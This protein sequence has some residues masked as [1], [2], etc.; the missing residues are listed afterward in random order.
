MLFNNCEKKKWALIGISVGITALLS[1]YLIVIKDIQSPDAYL[2]G[3]VQYN[4]GDWASACGRWFL[5]YLEK[6]TFNLVMPLFVVIMYAACIV[7]SVSL[8]LRL[9]HIEE[10][11]YIVGISIVMTASPAIIEQL[12][13]TFTALA[14]A[15]SLLLSVGYLFLVSSSRKLYHSF[16]GSICLCLALGLYQSYIGV[17]VGLAAMLLAFEVY[18]DGI[19]RMFWKRVL[20]YI[21]TGG[22]GVLLYFICMKIDSLLHP[23]LMSERVQNISLQSMISDFPERFLYTYQ[24]FF[25]YFADWRMKRNM[26]YAILALIFVAALFAASANLLRQ[27]KWKDC[28]AFL[29]ILLLLP[30]AMNSIALVCTTDPIRNLMS[31][32]MVLMIPFGMVL[33]NHCFKGKHK[34]GQHLSVLVCLLISWTYIISA[35]TTYRCYDLSSKC[36]HSVTQGIVTEIRQMPEYNEESRIIF[37]GF[38]DDS[39]VRNAYYQLYL[40]A[41]GLPNNVVWWQDMNGIRITRPYLLINFGIDAGNV[42]TD[43]YRSIVKSDAFASMGIYPEE[44]SIAVING[45]ITVKLSSNPPQ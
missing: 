3:F 38:V 10:T 13:Y 9:L 36:I 39:P 14:Y 31:Y 12:T 22:L 11:W 17:S 27:K 4:S 6:G 20:R 16:A 15:F 35:N 37:A 40:Y 28:I 2:E 7:I 19:T 21:W 42:S 26:M 8:I 32:Q 29:L 43:E 18:E 41:I 45:I 33:V 23:I 34:V 30:P 44:N 5:R 24:S 25:E 1:Y